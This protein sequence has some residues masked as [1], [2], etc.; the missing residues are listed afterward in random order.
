MAG[1]T[2]R[3]QIL[4]VAAIM[5]LG[6]VGEAVVL[7][8][9]TDP[10]LRLRLGMLLLALVAWPLFIA[11][12]IFPLGHAVIAEQPRRRF[13]RLRRWTRELL[14]EI[15]RL[16]WTVVDVEHGFRDRA[17]ADTEIA[18]IERR[19][20]QIIEE[21]KTAAGH[22]DPEPESGHEHEIGLRRNPLPRW[23]PDPRTAGL[24]EPNPSAP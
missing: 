15:S 7:L 13:S 6:V 23:T 9:G 21:I 2:R 18:A 24:T 5:L 10:I 17:A 3:I 8:F 11:A 22:P 14:R 4:V 19:L 16:N 12:R 1:S 20:F